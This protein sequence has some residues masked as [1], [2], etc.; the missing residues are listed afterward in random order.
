MSCLVGVM[1]LVHVVAANAG[2]TVRKGIIMVEKRMA[3]RG[4]RV[5]SLTVPENARSAALER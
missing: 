1:A 4:A 2:A 3:A 5:T